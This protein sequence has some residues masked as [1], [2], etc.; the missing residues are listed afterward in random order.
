MVSDELIKQIATDLNINR[1]EQSLTATEYTCSVIYS[2]AALWAKVATQDNL[3][4]L[5]M[6]SKEH[7]LKVCKEFIDR[8]LENKSEEVK[9]YFEPKKSNTTAQLSIISQLVQSGELV[10]LIDMPED[11]TKLALPEPK[12]FKIDNQYSLC[13]GSIATEDYDFI[14]AQ[15]TVTKEQ[16]TTQFDF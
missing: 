11:K 2:A 6:G 3:S 9:N 5:S 8:I 15:T 16:T 1:L 13:A 14:S 12:L 10:E 7:V 4:E